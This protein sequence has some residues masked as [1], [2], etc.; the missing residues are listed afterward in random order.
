MKIPRIVIAAPRSGSGKTL[1]TIGLIKFLK[2]S[3]LK[4]NSFK[5]GPDYID[6][7]F[8][9]NVL[10][11]DSRN[12]DL[13]FT[14]ENTTRKIFAAEND[15]ELSIIEGVMGLYDGIGGVSDEASTYHLAKVLKA[16]II[17][18]VDAKGMSRSLIAMV[19]GFSDF[20]SEGLIKGIVL[21]NIS[22]M[23]YEKLS[24]EIEKNTGIKALGY[25]E[26]NKDLSLE[27]RHL[28]LVMPDEISGLES[29][30]K[31]SAAQISRTVDVDKIIE[32]AKEGQEF[33]FTADEIIFPECKVKIA[34]AF[35]DAFCFYYTD[36]IRM[37]ENMGAEIRKFSPLNDRTLPDDIDGM[38]LGGGYPEL[39]LA[40]LES[41]MTMKDSIRQAITDGIPSIAECGGFMYLH[42]SITDKDGRKFKMCGAIDG[43]CEFKG[44]LVRFG[45]A[46]FLDTGRK[47][48]KGCDNVIRGHEFH[49]YDSTSNGRDCIAHKPLSEKKWNCVH[50]D[51]NRWW[52][53][54]HLYYWS[55]PDYAK[56]FLRECLKFRER[57]EKR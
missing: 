4:V 34:L 49:Y 52:G 2:D 45:Y 6:P 37:L 43:S 54:P 21:N 11:L 35:D 32:I 18:V 13:F 10:G 46:E 19:K 14:D 3:C 56:S 40:E 17:L 42:E 53:F 1:F 22:S 50:A 47:F 29:I 55:N 9:R 25:F 27:S 26:N 23:L 20:D 30:C 7:M 24:K 39:H 41:N 48:L 57:R 44:S 31:I 38:I 8:H 28:G 5:T 16:P 33:N 36:N 15:S 51:E 12:L